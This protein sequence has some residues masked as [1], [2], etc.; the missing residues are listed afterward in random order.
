MPTMASQ[1]LLSW[2]SPLTSDLTKF[3]PSLIDGFSSVATVPN[4]LQNFIIF[5]ITLNFIPAS[6]HF[7][8]RGSINAHVDQMLSVQLSKPIFDFNKLLG[9]N[10]A[11][12][13]ILS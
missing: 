8:T 11:S 4:Y 5:K 9:Y 6:Q 10:K 13:I 3:L 2:W 7:T 1:L 12:E